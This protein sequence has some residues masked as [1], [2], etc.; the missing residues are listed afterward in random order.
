[1]VLAC[2]DYL[3][4]TVLVYDTVARRPL[5]ELRCDAPDAPDDHSGAGDVV[6]S[7]DGATLVTSA[8]G[9]KVLLWD[10][11]TWKVRGS[12]PGFTAGSYRFAFSPDSRLL[13]V[14]ARADNTVRLWDVP[15]LT[16]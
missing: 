9:G 1:K 13:A 12:L 5:A 7:P 3:R 14:G 10:A 11:A 15:A 4:H 16:E 8:N 2:A 6:F